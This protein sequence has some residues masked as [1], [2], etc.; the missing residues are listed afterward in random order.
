MHDLFEARHTCPL[1]G[2]PRSEAD[3]LFPVQQL[4]LMVELLLCRHCGLAYKEYVPSDKL[5]AQIYSSDYGLHQ[6]DASDIR[7]FRANL[8]YMG[9]PAGRNHLDYGCGG[10]GMV[11]AARQEGWQSFGAD[12]WLPDRLKASPLFFKISPEAGEMP[13]VAPFQLI[14]MWS[15]VEHLPQPWET[16][17][18]LVED[19]LAHGGELMFNVPSAESLAAR[20]FQGCWRMALLLEHTCFFT[21]QTVDY[22]ADRLDLRVRAVKSWGIPWPFG[23]SDPGEEAAL[24]GAP[25]PPDVPAPPSRSDTAREKIERFCWNAV[26]D[27]RPVQF[28]V[29]WGIQQLRIGDQLFVRY[30]KK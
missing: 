8:A 1:C 27:A 29:R 21:R 25:P 26:R 30:E 18:W 11:Q 9:R 2:Q 19:M 13:P 16:F 28:M 6:E 17:R 15:V 4:D 7:A 5:F 10:G 23:R 20:R 14:T 12:P 3:S 24:E 22:L